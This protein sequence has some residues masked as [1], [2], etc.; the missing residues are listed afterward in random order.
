M[1]MT[2]LPWLRS[3][4]L[5]LSLAIH[6]AWL[7]HSLIEQS[8]DNLY[9][10]LTK[11]LLFFL[12]FMFLFRVSIWTLSDEERALLLPTIVGFFFFYCNWLHKLSVTVIEQ[13]S[14]FDPLSYS[15]S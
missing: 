9:F 1:V 14:I 12:L 7:I 8:N 5:S 10:S 6:M 11:R 3:P 2:R 4:S 13:L 15:A